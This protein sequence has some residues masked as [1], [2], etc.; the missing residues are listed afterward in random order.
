MCCGHGAKCPGISGSMKH[1]F[2]LQMDHYC[3]WIIN[4]V[5]LLNYKAFLLFLVYAS[6]ACT[7]GS[8]LMIGSFVRIMVDGRGD[9]AP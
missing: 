2:V 9:T 6:L 3:V 8:A 1:R 7:L 4:C 5:G